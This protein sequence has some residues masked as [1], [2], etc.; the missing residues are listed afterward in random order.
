MSFCKIVVTKNYLIFSCAS[1]T[2][3]FNNKKIF[4]GLHGIFSVYI[5]GFK[6]F[7]Q[8]SQFWSL[9]SMIMFDDAK[10]ISAHRNRKYGK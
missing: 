1:F 4:Y 7:L 2:I 3:C 8:L 10:I 5:D 6:N 9:E